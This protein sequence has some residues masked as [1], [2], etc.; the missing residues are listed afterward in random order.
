MLIQRAGLL[1]GSGV[2]EA[3]SASLAAIAIKGEL[4]DDEKT[5]SSIED[6]AIHFPGVIVED[7]QVEDFRGEEFGVGC[8]VE[9]RDAEQHE[10]SGIDLAHDSSIDRDARF[11]DALQ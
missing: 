5:S 3:G 11:G 10:K 9:L 6:A 1:G 7:P 8:G 4:G 2:V